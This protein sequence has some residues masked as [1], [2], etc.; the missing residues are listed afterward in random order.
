LSRVN[1]DIKGK[2]KAQLCNQIDSSATM[3]DSLSLSSPS[4]SAPPIIY[5]WPLNTSQARKDGLNE[6]IDMLRYVCDEYPIIK[7]HFQLDE[8]LYKRN[9]NDYDNLKLI[10]DKYNQSIQQMK[11]K[12]LLSKKLFKKKASTNLLRYIMTQ[13]YNKGV[14]EP[15]KL[16]HYEPFSPQVYGETSFDLVT[17]ILKRVKLSANEIFADLGSGVG[18]VVLQVAASLNCKLCY[19]IEK[20]DCPA[21]YAVAMQREFENLMKWFGRPYSKFVIVKGDF[22]TDELEQ[23][24]FCKYD[25]MTVT[26]VIN[27]A[28]LI[29]VNNYA[30]GAEVDHQLKIKFSNMSEGAFIVSSKPF[31]PLNFRITSRNLND[32]GAILNL[33]EFA[34]INGHVSW[35]DRPINYYFHRIDR[36]LLEKYFERLKNPKSRDENINMGEGGDRAT[37]SAKI[38]KNGKRESSS[39]RSGSSSGDNANQHSESHEALL[40]TAHNHVQSS[41]ELMD[42][43]I[44]SKDDEEPVKKEK[45]EIKKSKKT[46]KETSG[47]KQAKMKKSENR[48]VLN[49]SKINLIQKSSVDQVKMKAAKKP[50]DTKRLSETL[51]LM[52]KETV[53]VS[54]ETGDEAARKDVAMNADV[55]KYNCKAMSK[56]T[57]TNLDNRHL[58]EAAIMDIDEINMRESMGPLVCNAV[59]K[60]MK[61]VNIQI[62]NYLYKMKSPEYKDMLRAQIEREIQIKNEILKK[63]NQIDSQISSLVKRNVNLLKLRVS[64][65]AF[66]DIKT[67]NELI[68]LAR[69]ILS[70]HKD[71]LNKVN[72]LQQTVDTLEMNA[73]RDASAFSLTTTSANEQNNA[74]VQQKA[75]NN[76]VKNNKKS[77]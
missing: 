27:E 26:Q 36:T 11:E 16:N 42:S 76:L 28:K 20:A 53:R 7:T 6:I 4:N 73:T 57:T 32:I 12:E 29:F 34:A 23:D 31:C 35:T 52:H 45:E 51:N 64:E 1:T 61:S 24:S 48:D 8:L 63:T 54:H 75:S 68:Q 43:D 44:F 77:K 2:Q 18:N 69:T 30:F 59:D 21:E 72:L 47:V 70:D 60:Y 50:K 65:L 13:I 49:A 38:A 41:I 33:N 71:L 22:L 5:E 62:L 39:S 14:Q 55:N 56:L 19:G 17:E 46:K 40:P 67:P 58:K 74:Q 37:K 10:C 9:C 3:A 15:E 66:N 25:E